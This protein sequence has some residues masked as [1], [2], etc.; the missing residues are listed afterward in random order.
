MKKF[1][2]SAIFWLFCTTVQAQL[3]QP[4]FD[5]NE[6]ISLMNV[7]AQFGD[8][9]YSANLPPPEGWQLVYRSPVV[10][11]DN[12]WDLWQTAAGVPVISIRGTTKN[13]ISW[14][15]NFY[16]AMVPAKGEL[17]LSANETFSY[18]LAED[19]RAA[20]HTGW[21]IGTGFL[22]KDMLPKIDSFYKSGKKE[23]YIMGHSQGGAIAFL[24]TSY[25]Y[26]LQKQKLLPASLRFKTYCSAAPKP[27]NLYYA[28]DYEAL[29]QGGWSC[30]VVNTVD[31]VP[32]TPFSV[33]TINDMAE[34]NPF[35]DAKAFI[36]R[37]GWPKRW[38][39]NY[40]YGRL[41]KPSEKARKNYRKYLGSY[42]EKTIKKALP[43]FVPP[44]YF[45]SSDYVRVGTTIALIPKEDY[46]ALYPVDKSKIFQNHFHQPYLYLVKK[47]PQNP[48]AENSESLAGTWEM[49]AMS[50]QDINL[51]YA[52]KKPLLRIEPGA[53]SVAGNTGCNNFSGALQVN[54]RQISFPETM[55]MTKMFCSGNGE[56]VF[57]QA[58]RRVNA[59]QLEGS[60]L[61]LLEGEAVIMTFTSQ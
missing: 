18:T 23:F 25:L 54:G 6:Y 7:S 35:A 33:Q 1:F 49:T 59:Y 30:N 44:A 52:R 53:T 22:A 51:L 55:A 17:Q 42:V 40:A 36:K 2:A 45:N 4:G 43:G 61:R 57:L 28:Y 9:A 60:Q 21:L 10:G 39:L 47:L 37:F 20:V 29:T 56:Q 13:E 16:A 14:M 32:Q 31:W 15:E 38:A 24:L 19:N 41:T 58:L 12:R 3:L 34:V 11:L 46:F 5:R 8:S 48:K 26:H 50:N 27:G